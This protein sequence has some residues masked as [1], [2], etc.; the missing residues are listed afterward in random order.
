MRGNLIKLTVGDYLH[1]VPGILNSVNIT[2]ENGYPWDI[3][4]NADGTRN[5]KQRALPT[6]LNVSGFQ[7]TPIHDH[8]PMIGKKFINNRKR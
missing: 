5:R 1:E 3:A 4:R 8:I 6:I 2:I 7:F